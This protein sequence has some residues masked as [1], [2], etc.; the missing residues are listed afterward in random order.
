LGENIVDEWY[1]LDVEQNLKKLDVDL[2]VGLDAAEA[3]RRLERYGANELVERDQK[4]PWKILWEQLT[5]FMVLIL[6]ASAIISAFLHEYT[7]AITILVIVVLNAILGF[8]Q[9]Y[10]AEKAM[11]ALK[12]MAAPPVRVR[13]GG[14]LVE[15]D[16]RL[17][18]PGD[19]VLVEAG[20]AVPAACRVG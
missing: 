18:V 2:S 7:E 12:R 5:G 1:Q 17:V 15:L 9:E 16:S 6:L 13:R 8:T 11:L 19:I 4:S 20:S 10:N 3:Q 14:H